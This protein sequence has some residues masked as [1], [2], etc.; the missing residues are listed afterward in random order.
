MYLQG[1]ETYSLLSCKCGINLK[2][3]VCHWCVAS[4]IEGKMIS[5]CRHNANTE[6]RAKFPF[7]QEAWMHQKKIIS[8]TLK[9]IYFL[10]VS[11][12]EFHSKD[13]NLPHINSCNWLAFLVVVSINGNCLVWEKKKGQQ[14]EVY[15]LSSTIIHCNNQKK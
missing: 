7:V 14:A 6:R 5:I 10:V 1:S 2:S 15:V 9:M 4:L 12:G 8:W 3:V 11:K 13:T